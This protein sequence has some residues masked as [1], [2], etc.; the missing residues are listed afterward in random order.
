VVLDV[1]RVD[2]GSAGSTAVLLVHTEEGRRACSGQMVDSSWLPVRIQALAVA[3]GTVTVTGLRH[4]PVDI[5]VRS[6]AV[7]DEEFRAT[8]GN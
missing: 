1:Q 3:A 2:K 6:V 8:K 5:A 7:W 4:V